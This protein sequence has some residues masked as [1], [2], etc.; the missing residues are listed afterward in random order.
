MGFVLLR[1]ARAV[2][3]GLPWMLAVKSSTL[4]FVC[5][6]CTVQQRWVAPIWHVWLSFH[7]ACHSVILALMALPQSLAVSKMT[8]PMHVTMHDVWHA[9]QSMGPIQLCLI[10]ITGHIFIWCWDACRLKSCK[11]WFGAISGPLFCHSISQ[12]RTASMH[13]MF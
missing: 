4:F 8:L 13:A 2:D 10:G 12:L 1:S 7:C 9:L 6:C 3:Q 5:A 11:G